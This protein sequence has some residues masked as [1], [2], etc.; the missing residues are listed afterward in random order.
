M[1]QII[2]GV[3]R[4]M[5]YDLRND[6]F[7]HLQRLPPAFYQAHR[8][9]DLMSR[10]TNDLNAVRMM[11]GPA[12]MYSAQTT[13]VFVVAIVLMVSIDPRLTLIALLPLPLVSVSVKL[14]RHGDPQAVRAHPGPVG[15]DQRRRAGERSRACAS[16]GPTARRRRARRVPRGQRGVRRAQP[17]ADRLQ[18]AFYPSLTLCSGWARCWCSG[19]AAARSSPD[20][21]RSA[22]SSPSTRYLVMLAWPLIA[23]GWV[24]NMLQRG[25]ASWERMLEVL[26]APPAI[27]RSA[28]TACTLDVQPTSRGGHRVAPPDVRLSARRAVLARRRPRSSSRG[29]R[30]RSSAPPAAASRRSAACCR[31]CTIR[32]RARCSRRRRRPRAAAGDAARRHRRSCR[33]SH[34]C[35]RT[36]LA[37]T[38]PSAPEVAACRR[39][40]RSA[41]AVEQA[42]AAARG[43]TR[44]S[45]DFPH[46]YDTLVGERGITLSGGQKQRTALARALVPNPAS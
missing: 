16:S 34:F 38:S 29:R 30:S 21:S 46:G 4:H 5:E 33:R 40:A 3:S 13:L 1:R 18:G 12:V 14:L 19:S 23:F 15:R 32:R 20:A 8:T 22:S 9:G 36:R 42:A 2:I 35:S 39:D 37:A 17:R 27:A 31:A 43:S 41:R 11:V 25:M 10:A 6:F 26:D 45:R 28:A 7:A 44:T 24:T